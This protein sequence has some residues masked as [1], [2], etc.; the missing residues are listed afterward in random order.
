MKTNP[1]Y[2]EAPISISQWTP[3]DGCCTL[4]EVLECS[5]HR[6]LEGVAESGRKLVVC[7]KKHTPLPASHWT[8]EDDM[9]TK[10]IFFKSYK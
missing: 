7:L 6:Y 8:G 2:V 4:E 3:E 5:T 10:R 9:K 1:D